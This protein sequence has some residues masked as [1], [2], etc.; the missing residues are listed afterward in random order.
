MTTLL[1]P[2]TLP[3][4][5]IGIKK[6][7]DTNIKLLKLI[8]CVSSPSLSLRKTVSLA[9]SPLPMMDGLTYSFQLT[10]IAV[11]AAKAS[12]LSNTTG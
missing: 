4:T 5:M 2:G 3:T 12:V 7:K 10:T 1:Q 8:K 9:L 11:N 6:L